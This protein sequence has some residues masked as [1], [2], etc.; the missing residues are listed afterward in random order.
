MRDLVLPEFGLALLPATVP[1]SRLPR[2][3]QRDAVQ[4]IPQEFGP[5]NRAGPPRQDQ[6]SRL[7]R[8][9]GRMLIAEDLPTDAQDQRSVP[10][11]EHRE[12][13]FRQLVSAGAKSRQ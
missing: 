2:R 10:A 9:F 12:G 3:A 11:N 6:E 13:N 5:A 7:K 8:I 1:H 4:P